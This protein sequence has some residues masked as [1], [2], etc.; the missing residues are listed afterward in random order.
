M[1]N[2]SVSTGVM[3][4][5]AAATVALG[6]CANHTL[7]PR[8]RP[9]MTSI[10][11]RFLRAGLCEAV[12]GMGRGRLCAQRQRLDHVTL[13]PGGGASPPPAPCFLTPP[14]RFRPASSAGTPASAARRSFRT[15]TPPSRSS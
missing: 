10:L 12:R 6:K 3:D 1:R 2:F 15:S 9:D 4:E 7:Y 13:P 11:P 8:F 14:S 5:K